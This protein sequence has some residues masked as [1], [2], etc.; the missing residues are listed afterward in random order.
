MDF[1]QIPKIKIKMHHDKLKGSLR[2]SNYEDLFTTLGSDFI[3]ND[4]NKLVARKSSARM[5]G[6]RAEGFV[7]FFS[8]RKLGL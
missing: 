8:F 1:Y 3:N 7:K 4:L 5:I 6:L 2:K